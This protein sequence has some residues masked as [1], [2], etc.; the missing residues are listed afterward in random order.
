MDRRGFL[1]ASAATFVL[2]P[3]VAQAQPKVARVGLIAFGSRQYTLET[4]RY[5]AFTEGLHELGYVEGKNLVVEARFTDGKNE[6][7]PALAAELVGLKVDV[8]VGVGTPALRALHHATR[9]VPVVA[10]IAADPVG[11]RF[12]ASLSRP[13][14]N[15]TGLSVMADELGPSSSSC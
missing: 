4:G 7:L 12:A 5:Q 11:D 3:A 6:G 9:T 14:G 2:V 10:P 15:V 8:I 1:S 13:D